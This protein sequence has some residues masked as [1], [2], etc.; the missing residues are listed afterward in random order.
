MENCS[1]IFHNL[2]KIHDTVPSS[3][4]GVEYIQKVGI[5]IVCLVGIVGNIL[6]IIILTRENV[7][8]SF[9]MME[10]SAH[11]GLMALA[12]SDLVFCIAA[13]PMAFQR[14][15]L[16]YTELNFMVYY[17][18][19]HHAILNMLL[20]TSTWLTVL[21]AVGRYLAICHPLY[22]RVLIELKS[23]K[24]IICLIFSIS[25]GFTIPSLWKNKIITG[26]TAECPCYNPVKGILYLNKTFIYVY[27]I[28]R[29]VLLVF[30]PLLLLSICNFCLIRALRK[31]NKMRRRYGHTPALE[32][33]NRL[34]P[35]LISIIVLNIVLVC[36]SEILRFYRRMITMKS[37]DELDLLNLASN[38]TNFMQLVNFAINFILYFVINIHFRRAARH[39]VMCLRGRPLIVK[40]HH[41]STIS[42]S[43][44]LSHNNGDANCLSDVEID[45]L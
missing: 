28:T 5:P 19:H 31:S 13:F 34:T 8:N 43:E 23:T 40:Q 20:M 17:K 3:S 41:T 24:I 36:P 18:F 30:I 25:L 27:E 26:C 45:A 22:A 44:R 9:D 32:S 42:Q 11:T 38:V 7:R 35:T 15:Q 21:M 29:S 6:N 10:R 33:E 16:L 14:V 12:V 1:I 37:E 39:M 2:S 4:N